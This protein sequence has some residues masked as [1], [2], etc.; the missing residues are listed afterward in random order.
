MASFAGDVA[1]ICSLI[2]SYAE[3]IDNGDV[4]GIV[5]LFSH[6]SIVSSEGQ[7]FS[8]RDQLRRLWADGLKL[9]DGSPRTHHLVTNVDVRL[10][11]DTLHATG[12]S[13]ITVF[14]A[15][16]GF[17]LQA[18]AAGHHVDTFEKS[19]GIW[20]FVERRDHR[21]LVGDLS[22]HYRVS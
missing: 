3:L 11:E 5:A 7:I 21:D 15:L 13:Y 10:G 4:D 6:A 20:R 18:I 1:E 12:K 9:H 14:Q 22:N 16:P 8:G 2:Y 17:P 19:N